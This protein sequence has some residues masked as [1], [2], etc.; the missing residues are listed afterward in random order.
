VRTTGLLVI[1]LNSAKTLGLTVS[2]ELLARAD[3]VME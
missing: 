2:P 1:N 3:E